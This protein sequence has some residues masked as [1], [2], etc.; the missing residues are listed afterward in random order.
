MG[1]A[2][3]VSGD[4]FFLAHDHF[5]TEQFIRASGAPFTFLRTSLHT[6]NVPQCVS[7]DD[8]LC[9]SRSINP[10]AIDR[11]RDLMLGKLGTSPVG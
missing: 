2:F 10:A 7:G 1:D 8:I 9:L 5:H 4:C 11:T 3:S 6:D